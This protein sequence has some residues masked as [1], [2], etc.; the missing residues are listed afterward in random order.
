[1]YS[2]GHKKTTCQQKNGIYSAK[3]TVE[4]HSRM[5]KQFWLF[6]CVKSKCNN[7][8]PESNELQKYNNPHQNSS[9]RIVDVFVI[10]FEYV[11]FSRILFMGYLTASL[12]SK[13]VTFPLVIS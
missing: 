10:D 5:M 13:K 12:F 1:M 8:H 4:L 7:R 9:W 11:H 2:I 3:C 6:T